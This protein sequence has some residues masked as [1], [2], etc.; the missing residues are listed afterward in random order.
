[1]MTPIPV[2]SPGIQGWLLAKEDAR[3]LV[4]ELARRTDYREYNSPQQ[5]MPT[6]NRS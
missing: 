3:L 1:M 4:A 2:Q 6:A 5:L